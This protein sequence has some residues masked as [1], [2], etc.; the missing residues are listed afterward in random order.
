VHTGFWY[1]SLG[2]RYHLEDPGVDGKDIK[3]DLQEVGWETRTG[4]IWLG[5]DGGLL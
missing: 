3:M 5:T 1:E 2:N 4:S